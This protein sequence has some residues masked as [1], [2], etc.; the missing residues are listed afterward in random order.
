MKKIAPQ[1]AS[2]TLLAA[3]D[4]PARERASRKDNSRKERNRVAEL[5]RAAEV[6]A[7]GHSD[8]KLNEILSAMTALKKGQFGARLPLHWA[9]VSG[10]IA[11]VFNELAELMERSTQD[12]SRISRVVG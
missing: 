4:A 7:N 10:K 5:E 11:E 6:E 12:L 9:G 1:P 3:G 8:A 2:S